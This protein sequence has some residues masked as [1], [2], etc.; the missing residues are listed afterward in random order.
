MFNFKASLRLN[1]LSVAYSLWKLTFYWA[2]HYIDPKLSQHASGFHWPLDSKV[3][4]QGLSKID[5]I[6]PLKR[7]QTNFCTY[8]TLSVWKNVLYSK[9]LT[10]LLSDEKSFRYL[11]SFSNF[12]IKVLKIVLIAFLFHSQSSRNFPKNWRPLYVLFDY[13]VLNILYCRDRNKENKFVCLT[14]PDNEV[15]LGWNVNDK[16]IIWRFYYSAKWLSWSILL[17]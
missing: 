12:E 15:V 9:Y 1:Y 11:K 17:F 16:Y 13:F 14:E 2:L 10:Q 7:N 4:L 6:E 3:Q 5:L 8:S